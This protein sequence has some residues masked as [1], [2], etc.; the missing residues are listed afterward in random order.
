MTSL[1]WKGQMGA[2]TNRALGAGAAKASKADVEAQVGSPAQRRCPVQPILLLLVTDAC[3]ALGTVPEIKL[4][5]D[6]LP[7]C[8]AMLA[9]LPVV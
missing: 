6:A 4:G 1:L 3:Q 2:L 8:E 5:Q 7:A 9:C